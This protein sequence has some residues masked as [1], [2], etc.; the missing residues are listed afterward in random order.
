VLATIV[1]GAG[2]AGPAA[3]AAE[4][5]PTA[6]PEGAA[7]PGT[8]EWYSVVLPDARVALLG[9]YRP[10][11]REAL[12]PAVL[13]LHGKD[14]PRRIYEE[15]ASRYRD[16]GFTAVVACWFEYE[17]PEFEDPFRC[18]GIGPFT[19]ATDA[20]VQGVR[21]VV[22]ATEQLRGI[23]ARRLAIVGQSYG[24]RMA[25]LQAA[26]F[27]ST[28]PVVSSCGSLAEQPVNTEPEQPRF[29]F[30]ADPEVAARIVAPVLVVHGDAD[31]IVPVGQAEAF[32]AAMQAAGH[33]ADL[34]TYATP[35]GHTIPWDVVSA[36]D[37]PS[38][39]LRDRFLEDTTTWMREQLER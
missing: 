27:G 22:D 36:I 23:S 2:L 20:A 5:E 16:A 13:V 26:A 35:A 37:D 39:L 19:G 14:G 11:D 34:V 25:L 18:P 15:L 38:Q 29:P 3:R 9:V 6:R 33:P 24:A 21:T 32:T 17:P 4:P 8:D 10:A 1:C 7:S 12:G 31:P 28:E 30:P